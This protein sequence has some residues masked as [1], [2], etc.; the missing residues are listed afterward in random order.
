MARKCAFCPK[1]AVDTGG[2]HVWDD[3]INKALPETR[4]RA[5]KRYTLDTPL[6]Q[7]DTDSMNEKLPVVCMACNNGWM[8]ALSQKVKD[9]F[10]RA[11]LD[12]EPF[13]LGA[14]D[15]AILS[16]FTF[17]KAVVTNHCTEG[18]EPFFTRAVRERFGASLTLP[19]L[20]KQWFAAY[21]GK[22]RMSAKSHFSVFGKDA[23]GPLYG[24]QFGSFTYVVGKLALQLFAPRWKN[25]SQRGRPVISLTPNAYWAQAAILFWPH[26]GGFFSWPP[27][28]HLADDTI[29]A[30]I[31]RFGNDINIPVP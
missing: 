25:I 21:E 10:G 26:N 12:G 22:F 9:R 19:P 4:Y 7:Y 23:P 14:R 5:R 20:L 31:E 15:A 27:P 28:K 30:F 11:M 13:S 18:H 2:E 8:S 16:A 29:Q 17:M 24:A 3:W 6:I 1:D